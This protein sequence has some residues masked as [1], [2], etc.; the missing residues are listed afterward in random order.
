MI[1]PGKQEKLQQHEM[2]MYYNRDQAE[3]QKVQELVR[4]VEQKLKSY[5]GIVNTQ[6]DR[7]KES[8]RDRI[9]MRKMRSETGSVKKYSINSGDEAQEPQL[10]EYFDSP[11]QKLAEGKS[12]NLVTAP[13]HDDI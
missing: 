2:H 1:Q 5:Q 10:H 12:K 11:P 4:S 7:Q 9:K 8:I 3:K 6:L 13:R